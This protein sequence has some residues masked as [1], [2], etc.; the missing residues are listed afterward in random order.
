MNEVSQ[1]LYDILKSELSDITA[2]SILE[3]RCKAAC[4]D[5]DALTLENIR[6]LKAQILAS[7]LL[8]GGAEKANVLKKKFENLLNNHHS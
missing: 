8:F 1:K 2:R 5:H 6:E 3:V 7:V 4:K